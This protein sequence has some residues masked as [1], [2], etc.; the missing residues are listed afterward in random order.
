MRSD[1][2]SA[3]SRLNLAA[4]SPAPRAAR[5]ARRSALPDAAGVVLGARDDRVALVV[6][7]GGEDLVGVPLEHLQAV[8]ALH[9]PHAARAVG[10]CRDDL[11]ALRVELDLRYFVFMALEECCAGSCEDVVYTS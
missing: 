4:S 1:L 7:R 6:E 5:S 2:I 10:G 3:G 9:V 8:A 11:V